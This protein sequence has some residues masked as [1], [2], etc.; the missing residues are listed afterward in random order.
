MTAVMETYSRLPVAFERGEGVYLYDEHGNA[1]LDGLS[2]IA[3]TGLGHAHPGVSG[4]I[5]AQADQ[6]LHTSNLYKIPQQEK[7]AKRLVEQS[8][9]DTVFFGNSGAGPTRLQ[10]R[11][12]DCMGLHAISKYPPL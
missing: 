6:L 7:L 2:G 9:M 12:P 3:V 11:L 10:S 1:Y 8:G 4:A 5:K